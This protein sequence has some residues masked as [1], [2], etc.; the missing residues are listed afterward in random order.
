MVKIL[1]GGSGSTSIELVVRARYCGAPT[2][3]QPPLG[4]D[5]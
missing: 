5:E 2:G 4:A 3:K 1:P